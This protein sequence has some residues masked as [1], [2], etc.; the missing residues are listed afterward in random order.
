MV[1]KN[2][3]DVPFGTV[4]EFCLGRI[5]RRIVDRLDAARLTGKVALV[6]DRDPEF[7]ANR[8]RLFNHYLQHDARARRLL[9]S[10]MFA[11]PTV[12]PGL[13]C[14]DLLAWETRKDLVQ[15]AG[16]FNPTNRW[17]AMFTK[18]PEYQLDYMGEFWNEGEFDRFLPQ[19]IEGYQPS[20]SS[21]PSA[22]PQP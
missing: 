15:K 6:F 1:K 11:D 4:Q 19:V 17:R 16:G 22:L 9:A 7:S 14:A 18:M 3:P 10:I 8:I 13:Q 20:V 5:M 12:Y 21:S 2:N